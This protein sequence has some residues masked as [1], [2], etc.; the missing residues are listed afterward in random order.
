MSASRFSS[1]VVILRRIGGRPHVLLLRCYAY[2]DFPKGEVEAGEDPLH[3]AIR[4]AAE[5]T[6][7]GNLR[8]RWGEAF[9]ET[10]PY[11]KGKVARYYVAES[12]SGAVDLPVNPELGRPE[13]H[14]YRWVGFDDAHRRLHERL[15]PIL[16]W[17]YETAA[18]PPSAAKEL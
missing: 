18:A 12:T 17:A 14:E 6:G 10:P 5:E 11:A 7:L 1:G 16:E 2:W 4:E 9:R 8:F 3:T 13:H 15:R